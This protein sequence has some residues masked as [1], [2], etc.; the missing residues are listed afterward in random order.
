MVN[1]ADPVSATY[2]SNK[3]YFDTET[4]NCFKTYGTRVMSRNLN[5]KSRSIIMSKRHKHMRALMLLM[6]IFS[7]QLSSIIKH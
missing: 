6:L 1:A 2:G 3:K 7:I 5:L 4:S